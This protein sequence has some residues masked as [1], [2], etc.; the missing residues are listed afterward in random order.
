MYPKTGIK[1]FDVDLHE[2]RELIGDKFKEDFVGKV[3]P[4]IFN[5]LNDNTPLVRHVNY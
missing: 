3:D 5:G 1:K 2:M 4:T